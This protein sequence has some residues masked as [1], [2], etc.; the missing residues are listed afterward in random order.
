MKSFLFLALITLLT[1]CNVITKIRIDKNAKE[2]L[3]CREQWVYSNLKDTVKIKILLFNARG[4]GHLVDFPNFIIGEDISGHIFGY[5]DNLTSTK[6]K[7]HMHY[8]HNTNN[9]HPTYIYIYIHNVHKIYIH[10]TSN[11]HI[12]YNQYTLTIHTIYIKHI[13]I[14]KHIYICI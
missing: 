10:Y 5:I 6:Y 2:Q 9:M 7:I 3:K 14:Y 12:V 13:Y 8:T 4:R 1:A 11:I